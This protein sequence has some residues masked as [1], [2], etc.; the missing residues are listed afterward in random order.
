MKLDDFK[1]KKV[2]KTE[3][4]EIGDNVFRYDHV[5]IQLNNISYF[6]VSPMPETPYPIWS[7]V[8]AVI[9]FMLLVFGGDTFKLIGISAILVCACIIG[10]IYNNNKKLGD[11]LTVVLNSGKDFYF[12]CDSK[13]FLYEVENALLQCFRDRSLK[14][15]VDLK[16]CLIVHQE[17]MMNFNNTGNMVNGNDNIVSANNTGNISN[18]GEISNEEWE[19]LENAFKEIVSQTEVNS[20]E[21]MLAVSAQ[22]QIRKRDKNGLH[23]VITENLNDFKNNILSNLISGG[24]IEIIK[25]VM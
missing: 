18:A 16:D 17:G 7:L 9:G 10:T 25:K 8:G 23:K 13:S 21:H 12:E 3:Q 2:I 14:Y 11:Y 6:N 22:Y 4:L 1:G 5:V 24:I 20:Y 15:S 19:K